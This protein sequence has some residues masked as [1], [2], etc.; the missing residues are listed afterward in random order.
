MGNTG[1]LF[2]G[3]LGFL[4]GGPVGAALGLGLGHLFDEDNS[5]GINVECPH[6]KKTLIIPQEGYYECAYCHKNFTYGDAQYSEEELLSNL[7]PIIN[8]IVKL[9]MVWRD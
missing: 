3:G 9:L 4:L 7:T 2:G 1:K 5:N 8:L 6:C